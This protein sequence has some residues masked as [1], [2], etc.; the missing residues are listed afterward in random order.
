MAPFLARGLRLKLCWESR[1]LARASAA[2]GRSDGRDV[3]SVDG[4]D[5]N[6]SGRDASG[7]VEG[8]QSQAHGRNNP[9]S[10]LPD[11]KE[12]GD[13]SAETGGRDSRPGKKIR[14]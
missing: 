10:S 8:F 4:T 9:G 13:L 12:I 1:K 3:K 6:R 14:V 2:D 7:V 5:C 11:T